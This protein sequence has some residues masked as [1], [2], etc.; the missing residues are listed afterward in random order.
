MNISR[1]EERAVL[2]QEDCKSGRIDSATLAIRV[3]FN[4]NF[5]GKMNKGTDKF[6]VDLERDKTA[7]SKLQV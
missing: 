5:T 4:V 7:E 3:S 6:D 2:P 1:V